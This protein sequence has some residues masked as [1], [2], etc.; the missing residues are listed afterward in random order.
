MG[1]GKECMGFGGE[2][3]IWG[4]RVWEGVGGERENNMG[5]AE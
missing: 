2:R 4:R 5:D 3:E 1:M